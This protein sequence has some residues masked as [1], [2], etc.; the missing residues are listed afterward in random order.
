ML[1]TVKVPVQFEPIFEKAHAYV[2][3]YFKEK[4]EDPSKGTIEIFGERY[5]LVRA[6]SMSVEFFE[7]IVNLYENE[8]EAEALNIAR[9]L[10]FDIAHAIGKQ[11]AR[12]FHIK[13]NLQNPIEKLSVGPI[14]FSYSGWAFVDIFPESKPSPDENYYLIYDHPYAFESAAWLASGKKSDFPVCVMNAGYSSG[15]CEESFGISLVASEVLC[16]AKGDP[17]CRFIMAPPSKIREHI[18]TYKK[19]KP[20]LARLITKYEVPGFF[21]RKEI[22]DRLK[23]SNKELMDKTEHLETTRKELEVALKEKEALLDVDKINK[24]LKDFAYIVSHDLK[25]PLRGISQLAEWLVEDYTE[26]LD[27]AGKEALNLIKS[28]VIRMHNMIEGIFEFSKIGRV[29]GKPEAVDTGRIVR[30]I[31]ESFELPQNIQIA[32]QEPLPSIFIDQLL[33]S[34][35][36]ENLISN[37]VKYMDKPEGLVEI[38]GRIADSYYEFF[39]K[40][41]GPGIEEKHFER[42]FQLFQTLAPKDEF[43][44]T[45]IGL[46]IVKKIIEQN[47]GR[48]WVESEVHTGS[49][50]KFT[51]PKL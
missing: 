7:T 33:I 15:W 20:E 11:D 35:I 21:K 38:G 37:A 27:D 10:L 29:I 13:N 43:E 46:T 39:V 51:I 45:G 44:S 32:I 42:I 31:V 17:A 2:N 1:S 30:Q 24:E 3:K 9:Q 12:N 48:I 5:L 50:F 49:T 8:G 22:E 23:K 41:N 16:I 34:Q 14:H 36:F 18:N 4:K 26:A 25:T 6:A 47:G 28:R 40:D 19:S